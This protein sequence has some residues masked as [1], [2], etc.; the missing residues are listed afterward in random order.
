MVSAKRKIGM[1]SF[2]EGHGWLLEVADGGV[3]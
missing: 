2:L 1:R 3:A